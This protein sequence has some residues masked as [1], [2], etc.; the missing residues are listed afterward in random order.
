MARSVRDERLDTRSA[1]LRLTPR[2]EPYWRIIQEGRSIG[3][4]RL[5][6]GKAG[7]W[8]AR[9]H[10]ADHGRVYRAMG[11]ADDLAD[12]DGRGTLNFPQ[13]QDACRAWFAAPPEDAAAAKPVTV[14]ESLDDYVADYQSRGGKALPSLKNT[15][16]AH[17]RPAFGTRT[18]VSL[19][20]LEIKRWHAA[21]ASTAPRLRTGKAATTPKV[22]EVDG[23]D[24]QRARRSSA[25]RVLTVLRAALNLAFRDGRVASDA[26]WRRVRPFQKVDAARVRFLDDAEARRL[27]NACPEI[28][29][30]LVVAALLTGMRLGELAA[31]RVTDMDPEAGT[32]HIPITKSGAAR[33]TILTKEAVRFFSDLAAG[34]GRESLMLRRDDGTGWGKSQQHRP[35][36]DACARAKITPAV[37]FHILRHT[38]ASRLARAGVPMLAI[39]AQLGHAS[40]AVTHKH[41]AHL[42]P[43]HVAQAVRAG[44]SDMGLADPS[45][46]V[47]LGDMSA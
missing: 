41:Y 2:R 37:G 40:V 44:F 20:A 15:V 35:L 45:N 32:I 5:A 19:T 36:H 28:L 21:L 18:V 10:D 16:E 27:V 26:A 47:R 29:R 22:R 34:R 42:S 8:I 6:G 25:N 24:A 13:A 3:Y 46:V 9:R 43:D 1:R 30:R 31:M 39:A 17:L 33:H 11:S 4:R 38:H 14:S 23:P 12:A 7:S